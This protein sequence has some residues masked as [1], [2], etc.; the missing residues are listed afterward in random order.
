MELYPTPDS[1]LAIDGGTP[2]R[3]RPLPVWPQFG[4]EETEAVCA[5][6][7]SGKV[8][9]WTGDEGRRFEEEFAHAVGCRY[10]VA[11]ANGTGYCSRTIPE[12]CKSQTKN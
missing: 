8:N 6:L 1:H 9:Y 4:P 11:L 2:V 12:E 3:T 7:R 5:V 10:A